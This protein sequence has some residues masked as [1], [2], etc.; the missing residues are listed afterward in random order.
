MNSKTFHQI[1][2]SSLSKVTEQSA[3]AR[4]V[5]ALGKKL[6]AELELGDSVDTLGR[7][8][9]HY[10]AELIQEAEVATGD[11]RIAKQSQLRDS[12]LALWTH[13]FELPSGMRPFSE[14]EPILRALASLDPES[15]TPRYFST[16]RAPNSESNESEETRQWIELARS[17][18]YA[19][20]IL[21]D[22]CLISAAGAALDKSQE[23]IKLAN[24][25]GIDDSFEFRVIRIISSQRDLMKETDLNASQRSILSDRHKKLE[26]FL[27]LASVLA[28]DIKARV[29]AMPPD[30][31]NEKPLS[32]HRE[33]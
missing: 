11:D 9:A 17:I 28:N 18:D 16:S 33:S 25:A 15:E 1:P 20:K 13:R 22:H 21:I 24:E 32:D 14:F 8:M 12:I 26:G 31:V 27:S 29:K 19:S 3:R 4:A 2:D 30:D 23:W 10:L 6:V 5:V 7:W